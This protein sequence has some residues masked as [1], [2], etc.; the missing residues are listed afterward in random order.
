MRIRAEPVGLRSAQFVCLL[1]AQ[2]CCNLAGFNAPPSRAHWAHHLLHELLH[3]WVRLVSSLFS[4]VVLCKGGNHGNKPRPSQLASLRT[5]KVCLLRMAASSR[6]FTAPSSTT[7]SRLASTRSRCPALSCAWEASR[8]GSNLYGAQCRKRAPDA[9]PQPASQA[10]APQR[11]LRTPSAG[12]PEHN[13]C[14]PCS[15]AC[16]QTPG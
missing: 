10:E 1:E 15:S 6:A 7:S 16:P 12:R 14:L 5:I 2:G 11:Y 13:T 4:D 3:H 9:R 8:V